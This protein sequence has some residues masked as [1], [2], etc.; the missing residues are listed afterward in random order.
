[1]HVILFGATGMIGAGALLECLDDARITS[2]LAVVRRGT[3][4]Q[5][6]KLREAVA[7]DFFD[8]AALAGEFARGDACLF[9][10]GVSVAGLR[11]AEYTRLTY[12]LTCATARSLLAANPRMVFC[13]ISGERTDANGRAM[14]ARVKGRT[15][16]ALRAMPFRAVYCFRP[17][18]IIPR[19]GVR[20]R[21]P[22]YRWF[23]TV[24]RPVLPLFRLLMPSHTTTTVLLGRALIE[25]AV[26][27][28][29][30]A[31]LETREINRLGEKD[32]H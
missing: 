18:F 21:T 27:G 6:P 29:P 5:H 23:Y 4:I 20:S 8:T 7:S 14:W 13:Y 9:C 28:A 22:L 15:E 32:P 30:G 2:V 12:D 17:G 3:G 25:A 31:V 10:L 24:L 1:M 19:R 11:E 16:T 26:H